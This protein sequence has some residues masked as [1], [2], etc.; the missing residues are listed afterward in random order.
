MGGSLGSSGSILML[1]ST[2]R[3]FAINAP[4]GI[5]LL[6]VSR[7]KMLDIIFGALLYLSFKSSIC[8]IHPVYKA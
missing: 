3:L 2:K 4:F 8:E 6:S 5:Y 1:K 7:G